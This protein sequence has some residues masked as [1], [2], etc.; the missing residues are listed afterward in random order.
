MVKNVPADGGEAGDAG[1]TSQ[2]RRS[3]GEG[4]SNPLQYSCV[5]NPIDRGAWRVILHGAAN[6]GHD[7]ATKQ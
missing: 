1:S 2:S 5:G 4:N 6:S 3:P 7:L